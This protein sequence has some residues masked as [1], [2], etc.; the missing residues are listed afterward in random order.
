MRHFI[1]SYIHFV[2][3]FYSS[4]FEF[5]YCCCCWCVSSLIR[6]YCHLTRDFAHARR[7]QSSLHKH[8]IFFSAANE[9]RQSTYTITSDAL[10]ILYMLNIGFSDDDDDDV[11]GILLL[12]LL[13]LFF[14]LPATHNSQ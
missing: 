4:L 3:F 14:L 2:L 10:S 5:S 9:R 6:V 12:V 8:V 7:T 13:L 11:N 1:C